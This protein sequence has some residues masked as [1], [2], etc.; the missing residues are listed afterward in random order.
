MFVELLPDVPRNDDPARHLD[1]LPSRAKERLSDADFFLSSRIPELTHGMALLPDLAGRLQPGRVLRFLT[2][3]ELLPIE[4]MSAWSEAARLAG[5]QELFP[6]ERCYSTL[7]RRSRL[8]DILNRDTPDDGVHRRLGIAEWLGQLAE[9]RKLPAL[10]AAVLILGRIGDRKLQDEAARAR[11]IPV[12]PGPLARASDKDTVFLRGDEDLRSDDLSII[13]ERF[14]ADPEIEH[15]LEKLGFRELDPERKL[16]SLM[17]MVTDQSSAEQWERLWDATVDLLPQRTRDLFERQLF[18]GRPVFVRS[19]DGVWRPSR[20]VVL[21]LAGRFEPTNPSLRIDT[22][23]HGTDSATLR[24]AGRR[25]RR[26]SPLERAARRPLPRV[27]PRDNG[28]P[29]SRDRARWAELGERTDV[30]R[31]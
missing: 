20:T 3:N 17:H 25:L 22:S 29:Q 2:D 19:E 26:G 27:L 8:R 23:F 5:V 7:E 13:D 28:W 9:G 11:V 18:D 4:L 1:Y 31:A 21:P 12:G 10:E 6:H 15:I 24:A 16:L 14:I 30:L